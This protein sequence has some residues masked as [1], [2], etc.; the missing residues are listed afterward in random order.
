MNG[1]TTIIGQLEL[2]KLTNR[3]MERK[4]VKADYLLIKYQ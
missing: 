3:K 1:L 2:V 4:D